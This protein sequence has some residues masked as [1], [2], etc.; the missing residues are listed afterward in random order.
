[1][2][3]LREN[4]KFY[5]E[6]NKTLNYILKVVVVGSRDSYLEL[7]RNLFESIR[8]FDDLECDFIVSECLCDDFSNAIM[9]RLL[10]AAGHRLITL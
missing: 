2:L 9:N 10:K 7:S 5:D 1:V 6:L 8:K 4:Y 3:C